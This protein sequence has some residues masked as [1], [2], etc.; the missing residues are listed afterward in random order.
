MLSSLRVDAASQ[1]RSVSVLGELNKIPVCHMQLSPGPRVCDLSLPPLAQLSLVIDVHGVQ[2][3][4]G[5][6]QLARG[7][8]CFPF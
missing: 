7:R 3:Q 8:V 4:H 5:R 2:Q 1:R 6:S